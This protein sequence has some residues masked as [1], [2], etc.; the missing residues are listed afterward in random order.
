MP[1][2]EVEVAAGHGETEVAAEGHGEVHHEA[3]ISFGGVTATEIIFALASVLLAALALW[4]SRLVFV[5]LIGV[6][7]KWK[8]QWRPLYQLSFNKWYFD[9]IYHTSI[10]IPGTALAYAC[11]RFFDVKVVDGIVNGMAWVVGL[12]GQLARPLQTGFVRNYALYVLLGAVILM[13]F[14]LIK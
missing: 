13:L 7:E 3:F 14:S 2:H 11:W 12:L 8:A 5:P 1:A 4:W 6:T 9:E 10:V